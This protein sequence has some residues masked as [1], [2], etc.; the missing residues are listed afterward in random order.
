MSFLGRP[1]SAP[2]ADQESRKQQVMNEVKSQLGASS[3]PAAP[4]FAA[5]ILSAAGQ[6]SQTPRSSLTCVP[7]ALGSAR[8]NIGS[9]DR[10]P[11]NEREVVRAA[12]PLDGLEVSKGLMDE[13]YSFEKCIP[14]PGPSLSSSDETCIVRCTERFLEACPSPRPQ[15]SVPRAD[16]ERG[17]LT[18]VNIV[19][20][21]YVDRLGRERETNGSLD[22]LH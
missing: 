15:L 21:K 2:T 10:A 22:G 19:S 8:A 7:P 1:A 12:P 6:L 13:R 5:H 17:F 11:E 18:L 14:K 20:R 3:P 4:G 9:G 16:K